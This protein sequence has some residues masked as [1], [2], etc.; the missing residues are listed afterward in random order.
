MGHIIGGGLIVIG[1]FLATTVL[2]STVSE[3][4]RTMVRERVKRSPLVA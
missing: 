2:V 4:V 3:T 1:T